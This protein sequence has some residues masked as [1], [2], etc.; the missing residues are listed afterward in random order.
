M[1]WLGLLCRRGREP[2]S[3]S[4]AC[5]LLSGSVVLLSLAEVDRLLLL[6]VRFWPLLPVGDGSRWDPWRVI[7][8]G[9]HVA[10][11][12]GL[13]GEEWGLVLTGTIEDLPSDS[14]PLADVIA[15]CLVLPGKFWP[16][17]KVGL[18]LGWTRRCWGLWRLRRWHVLLALVV[19]CCGGRTRSCPSWNWLHFRFLYPAEGT[20]LKG[21]GRE[22]IGGHTFLH[23]G[24]WGRSV[25]NP[26][27][28]KLERG[29][30]AC[31][32]SLAASAGTC[33]LEPVPLCSAQSEPPAPT[34]AASLGQ[35]WARGTGPRC[36]S[37]AL[38]LC[39]DS[40]VALWAQWPRCQSGP[41]VGGEPGWAVCGYS[42]ARA[43]AV[44]RSCTSLVKWG[45]SVF[46]LF[47]LMTLA[48]VP[49]AGWIELV[50]ADMLELLPIVEGS[51]LPLRVKLAVWF[52][53][54]TFIQVED[55]PICS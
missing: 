42:P 14:M 27:Q 26:W 51:T 53:Y 18:G 24:R 4:D 45:S 44:W 38:A 13:V 48:G 30:L 8:G 16:A 39:G 15:M 25:C 31:P 41:A 54:I 6:G 12:L 19:H 17:C 50:K 5:L 35:C 10:G 34:S 55:V 23:R 33:H 20:G 43:H 28:Q 22:P 40:R 32:R 7:A 46:P 2:P 52:S 11:G 36:P 47:G 29:A 37:Q 49:S 9:G 3:W 1:P 21:E